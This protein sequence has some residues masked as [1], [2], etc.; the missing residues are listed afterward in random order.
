M[1]SKRTIQTGEDTA[2]ETTLTFKQKLDEFEQ[3]LDE[4]FG[5]RLEELSSV[6][7]YDISK[8]VMYLFDREGVGIP[9]LVVWLLV[10]AVFMTVRMGLINL[11]AF[12]HA[13]S[14]TRGT[15]SISPANHLRALYTVF[16]KM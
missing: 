2:G 11:R 7:L 5:R 10:G 16:S 1:L 13:I 8:P 15:F 9:F 12:G 6:L 4:F 14:V 3:T